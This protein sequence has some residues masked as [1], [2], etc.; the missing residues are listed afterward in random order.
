MVLIAYLDTLAG[1]SPLEGHHSMGCITNQPNPT[2]VVCWEVFYN[3]NRPQCSFVD[4]LSY[5]G[6]EQGGLVSS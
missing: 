2:M 4:A 3:M 5:A 1:T 6:Y